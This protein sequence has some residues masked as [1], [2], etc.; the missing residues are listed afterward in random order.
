ML[1]PLLNETEQFDSSESFDGKTFNYILASFIS[2]RF[3]VSKVFELMID[4]LKI[5]GSDSRQGSSSS[6]Q[7]AQILKGRWW[8]ANNN[9]NASGVE[10]SALDV[11]SS[12]SIKHNDIYQFEDGRLY[13]VVSVYSKSYNKWRIVQQGIEGGLFVVHF[14]WIVTSFGQYGY[15]RQSMEYLKLNTSYTDFVNATKL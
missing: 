4:M 2:N 8:G 5:G 12:N 3:D 7:K 1:P 13:R 9:N 11:E 15:S 14:A 10:S 6:S